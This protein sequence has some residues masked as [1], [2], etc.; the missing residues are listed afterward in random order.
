MAPLQY[1]R[2]VFHV[3]QPLYSGMASANYQHYLPSSTVLLFMTLIDQA[4]D[5]PAQRATSTVTE[6]KP[7]QTY[8]L[9]CGNLLTAMLLRYQRPGLF[10]AS[11]NGL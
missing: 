9:G 1:R 10:Q 2:V 3:K 6:H 4:P 7:P 5:L 8:V 11:E